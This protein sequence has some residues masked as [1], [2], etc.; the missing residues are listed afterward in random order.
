M[1]DRLFARLRCAGAFDCGAADPREG[2]ERALPGHH[3]LEIWPGCGTVVVF[4]VAHSMITNNTFLGPLAPAEGDRALGP[5][6]RAAVSSDHAM[7]RLSRLF[8]SSVRL[9]GMELLA[10]CGHAV[11]FRMPQLKLAAFEAGLGVYGRSGILLHP[12]LGSRMS[13]GAIMTDAVLE[14]DGRLQG[15]SP[16]EGCSLCAGACPA[17]AIDPGGSYPDSWDG[18]R[19]MGKRSR[20]E[21]AGYYC[22]NCFAVCPAG[23]IP[24]GRLLEI[25]TVDSLIRGFR[26]RLEPTDPS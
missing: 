6:P 1:K 5:V 24:E 26:F 18:E 10:E 20:V 13:L 12:V 7:D 9:K 21:D 19:C 23:T 8:V 11:S 25:R 3:P 4:A 15:F 14:P 17:G 22:N 16:C 2:F